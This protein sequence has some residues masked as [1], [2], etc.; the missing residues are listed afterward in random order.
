[1]D[2]AAS[3]TKGE[4]T[5][6]ID[7]IHL[8]KSFGETVV[9]DDISL[10][11]SQGE[12]LALIGP[13]GSG[14][15]TLL[16]C[17][18]LLEVPDSGTLMLDGEQIRYDFKGS[19]WRTARELTR[20]RASVGMVFQNFNLWPHKTVLENITEAPIRVRR[21]KPAVARQHASE[22]LEMVGLPEKR[23]SLPR[24]LSGGQQQRVAIARA[25]AMEPK[26][27]LFDEVTSAL[28]PELVGEVLDIMSK[29]AVSGMTMIVVTH[30]MGF[31]RHV[32]HRTAFL[33]NGRIE[34]I[35]PSPDVLGAPG[36]AH[37]RQFLNRVL[38]HQ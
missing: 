30:E 13:S 18:N 21:T 7:L 12:V 17:I 23:D 6:L 25:L 35:G 29:L 26:L 11:V 20:L 16:R 38:H 5:D 10:S 33:Y 34:E 2:A 8:R 31:A 14:K 28:D 27:M 32:S 4:L 15:S 19:A 22:L 9:L 3:D 37:T 24:Q 36:N 1:M